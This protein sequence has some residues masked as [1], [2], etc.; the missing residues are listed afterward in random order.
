[1]IKKMHKQSN[2]KKMSKQTEKQKRLLKNDSSRTVQRR[3]NQTNDL[4]F[5]QI[6]Q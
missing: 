1:M 4:L 6:F 3:T 2:N 5:Q